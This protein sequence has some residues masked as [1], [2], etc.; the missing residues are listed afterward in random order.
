MPLQGALCVERQRRVASDVI[1]GC[2]L[3]LR[4]IHREVGTSA[5]QLFE[6]YP[7]LQS[8]RGRPDAVMGAVAERQMSSDLAADITL[9][10]VGAEFPVI[11]VRG[12]V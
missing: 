3:S 5:E 10:G 11:A 6:R 7:R 2:E 9:V 12:G 8:N 1:A 4:E